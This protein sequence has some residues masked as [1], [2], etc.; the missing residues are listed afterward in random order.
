M[1]EMFCNPYFLHQ[2]CKVFC[3]EN[4]TPFCNITLEEIFLEKYVWVV[5]P[6]TIFRRNSSA[7]V[8]RLLIWKVKWGDKNIW[9]SVYIT[10]IRNRNVF[11]AT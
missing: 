8:L 4:I 10:W 1:L 2:C 7:V 9:L 5:L 6:K 11:I 3:A